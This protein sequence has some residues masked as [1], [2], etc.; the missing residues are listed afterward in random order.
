MRAPGQV[1][2]K[3]PPAPAGGAEVAGGCGVTPQ[4]RAEKKWPSWIFYLP[5]FNAFVRCFGIGGATHEYTFRLY[6][7]LGEV[8]YALKV[9]KVRYYDEEQ[10]KWVER[11]LTPEERARLK[12]VARRIRKLLKR[13]EEE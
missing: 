5:D 9:N 3:T 8:E 6:V 13:G 10:N 7:Q 11:E 4:R 1:N 2:A 12:Y